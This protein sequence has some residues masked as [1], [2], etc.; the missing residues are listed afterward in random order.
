MTRSRSVSLRKLNG[1]KSSHLPESILMNDSRAAF[2]PLTGDAGSKNG[3][4]TQVIDV[5]EFTVTSTMNCAMDCAGSGV[6][7][8]HAAGATFDMSEEDGPCG[9]KKVRGF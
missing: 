2:A 3:R 8:S 5:A 6:V 9:C 4:V 1:L 7:T